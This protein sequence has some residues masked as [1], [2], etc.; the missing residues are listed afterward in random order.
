[1]CAYVEMGDARDGKLVLMVFARVVDMESG[2]RHHHHHHHHHHHYHHHH[3]HHHHPHPHHYLRVQALRPSHSSAN[4]VS[5]GLTR[6]AA[7]GLVGVSLVLYD[8]S[9]AF[10]N[11]HLPPD[12]LYP[13][14]S[15]ATLRN[16]VMTTGDTGR[17]TIP[18][19][20]CVCST[21][22]LC[23]QC[24]LGMQHPVIVLCSISS[25]CGALSCDRG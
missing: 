2:V 8:S 13:P 6:G 12:E 24:L 17:E 20:R 4:K 16:K 3:H 25:V 22:S 11:A 9:L 23:M 21:K 5:S 18:R 7:K 19:R 14:G 1:M 15:P 10:I